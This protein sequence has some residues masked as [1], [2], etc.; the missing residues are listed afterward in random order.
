MV[1]MTELLTLL[2]LA[3]M[4]L[5]FWGAVKAKELAIRAGRAAC[6]KR[7]LQFLDQTVEQRQV[8]FG[9]DERNNPSWKRTYYFEFAS[10]G[11]FRYEGQIQMHG[12]RLQ[13][14]KLD[15][16]PDRRDEQQSIE[17]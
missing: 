4:A 8:R 15:P 6:E 1:T 11:E 17:H 16:Y 7:G 2:F 12:H 10:S 14:I 13:S 9:L 5:Y 3:L